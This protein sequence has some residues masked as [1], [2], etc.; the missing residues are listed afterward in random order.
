MRAVIQRVSRA[1]VSV[2]G[3]ETGSIDRGF[4]VFLAVGQ[5]DG[6]RQ[7]RWLSDKMAGLRV[8]ED[9]S[10]KMNLSLSE[11]AGE[12]L[13]VSQ[14]TL[15]GDCRK[16]RR[17]SFVKSAPP[18]KAKELYEAFIEALKEKGLVVGTGV[19][20]AHMVVDIVNDGPVTLIVDTPEDM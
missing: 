10:G 11:V 16:G 5:G 2:D 8:F 12:V 7:V 9:E 6:Q 13:L 18:D 17:P 3:V 20:Q 15:Y 1:A 4:C 19:F 14:F